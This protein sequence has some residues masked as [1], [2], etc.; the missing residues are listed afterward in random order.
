MMTSKAERFF[1]QAEI[2]FQAGYNIVRKLSSKAENNDP[3][4][5]GISVVMKSDEHSV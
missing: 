4:F 2:A 5:Y 3:D 1:I